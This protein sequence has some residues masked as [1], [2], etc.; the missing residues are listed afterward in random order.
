MLL[1]TQSVPRTLFKLALPM[2]AGTFAINAY[3]IA[4]AWFVSR[5]G[6]YPLA[7]MS[8]AMP[9]TMLL[10]FVMMALGAGTMT[11]VAHALGGGK[12][13][14]AARITSHSVLLMLLFSAALAAAGLLSMDW[15]F[16]RLGATGEA[17]RFTRQFMTVW[18]L[19]MPVLGLQNML[20][21]VLTS[22]GNTKASS[23]LMV[24]GTLINLALAPMMIFGLAGFPALGIRG[25]ALGTICSQCVVLALNMSI[26]TRRHRLLT[27]AVRSYRRILISWRRVLNIGLPSMYSSILAPLAMA[28]ITRLVAGYGETAVAALGVAGRVEMFSFMVPMS[29]GMSLTPFVAQNYGAGRL[30]R[31]HQARRLSTAFALGYGLLM[32]VCLA[33]TVPLFAGM[34]SAD[35]AVKSVLVRYIR[36]TCFGYGFMEVHRYS[37]FFMNGIQ[38]P[39]YSAALNT[40]RIL[41]LLI[42]LTM[43]GSRLYGLNGLFAGR[44][45]TDVLSALAGIYL[46]SRVQYSCERAAR[47]IKA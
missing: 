32:A 37:T 29:V 16:T 47:P 43:A 27:T 1:T 15:L 23:A 2:L 35:P 39:L 41:G 45:A 11:V 8:F 20:S 38:K 7:A 18:Y 34:F 22:T 21:S 13:A 30:D 36:I 26:L 42:P 44:L 6:T 12:Q 25:A 5:L 9:V 33:L 10:G 14:K 3:N 28:V 17:L 46:V 31:I 24:I 19:G 40:L 4:D